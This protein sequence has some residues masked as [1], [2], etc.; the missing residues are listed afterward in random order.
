M[1]YSSHAMIVLYISQYSVG[2]PERC[3]ELSSC[4]D[5]NIHNAA[6]DEIRILNECRNVRLPIR[7]KVE[8]RNIDKRPDYADY[9]Q[10]MRES[11][12]RNSGISIIANSDIY[13]DDSILALSQSLKPNQCAAL[14]RWDRNSS[15]A[16]ILFDRNDSQDVW[17]FRG[18]LKNIEGNFPVGVPR[19]DNRILFELKQAGYE[20]INPSF[21]VRVYH[22][23]SGVRQEYSNE[24]LEQFVDPPYAYLWPHNLWS[25]PRTILY[26]LRHPDARLS[27]RF[28]RRKFARSLPVRAV[29]KVWSM[30]KQTL[31]GT[32][33]GTKH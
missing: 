13:F 23:H 14:S 16:P 31:G 28:D 24:N 2:N 22:L 7:G 11:P 33:P 20:V 19:C 10:W 17:V 12:P 9:F 1:G 29:K 32:S 27:W 5:I 15:G 6:I 26:N 3:N 25:L 30:A 21:S 4:L 18:P 8:T